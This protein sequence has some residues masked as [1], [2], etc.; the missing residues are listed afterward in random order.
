[1]MRGGILIIGSLLWDNGE[2]DAWRR[3]RLRISERVHVKAPIH[4]GRRSHSRGN[5]FTM[6]LGTDDSRGRGQG[7]LV[8]CAANIQDVAGVVVEA[9]ALWKAEQ[10]TALSNSIGAS[11]GC[12]GA[13][14][15]TESTPANW[16][17]G[18]ADHF[19]ANASAIGPVDANGIL[20]IPWPVNA[21]DGRP[22]EMDVILGT[23]TMAEATRPTVADI[24]DAWVGQHEGHERYFF[25]N[26][27]HG[28]RTPEDGPIWRRI[29]EQAPRWLH[30]GAYDGV[31]A[32]LRSEAAP[33]A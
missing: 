21:V 25:E 17:A 20:R 15:R 12:V 27:R 28:I 8:P 13:L 16:L 3:S 2:R 33:C 18:W 14:F 4:Y 23:A 22:A 32:L 29:E 11:W 31:V 6:T 24:A 10:S 7:V 1:M 9:A 5:T 26:V 19:Q 30:G